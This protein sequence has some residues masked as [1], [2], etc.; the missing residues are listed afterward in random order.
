M[1]INVYLAFFISRVFIIFL[2]LSAS[3]VANVHGN[4]FENF[5][6]TRH[7]H[8]LVHAE[9]VFFTVS[10]VFNIHQSGIRDILCEH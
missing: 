4:V 8:R 7:L 1:L 10:K 6:S 2:L 5:F 9:A 3:R